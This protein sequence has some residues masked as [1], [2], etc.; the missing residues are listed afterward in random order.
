MDG[1]PLCRSQVIGTGALDRVYESRPFLKITKLSAAFQSVSEPDAEGLKADF[2]VR[3]PKDIAGNTFIKSRQAL[4]AMTVHGGRSSQHP[5]SARSAAPLRVP[6]PDP[7][8]TVRCGW[9]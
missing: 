4:A 5:F 1:R 9:R 7:G 6:R 3:A 8:R 2:G